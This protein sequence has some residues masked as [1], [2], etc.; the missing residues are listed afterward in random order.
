MTDQDFEVQRASLMTDLKEQDKNMDEVNS[1]MWTQ[2]ATNEL[3]F[4]K[5]AKKA[6]LLESIS[7]QEFISTF[8]DIF[9]SDKIHRVDY[10]LNSAA[11]SEE[12]LKYT[13]LN[14]AHV[15]GSNR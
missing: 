11:H 7:K 15:L 12:N 13:K 5:K 8:E 6:K 4:D 9:F 3:N 2:I 10:T 1:R 14:N